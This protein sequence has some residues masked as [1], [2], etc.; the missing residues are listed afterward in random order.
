M[1]SD[2]KGILSVI[3]IFPVNPKT[4]EIRKL[5]RRRSIVREFSLNTSMHGIPGIARSESVQNR[6]FWT[7]IFLI[8]ASIMFFFI[9]QAIRAYFDYPTQTSV[10]IISER[11]QQFPALTFCNAGAFRYDKFIGPFLNYVNNLNL[12]NVM[13][14]DSSGSIQ[15]Q[16]MRSYLPFIINQGQSIEPFMYTLDTMMIDCQFEQTS[17]S[18]KDFISFYSS[19]YGRCFTFNAKTKNS[20]LHYNY[21]SSD[22][23]KLTVRLYLYSYQYV[24]LITEGMGMMAMVHDNEQL[25]LIERAGMTLAPG[26]KHRLTFTKK[27]VYSL[28]SPYSSCTNEIPLAMKI[29][30]DQYEG[31]DYTY[32]EDICY[33][34]CAQAYIYDQCGCVF[35]G[36]WNARSIVLPGTNKVVLAPL[37]NASDS[38]FAIAMHNFDST[39]SIHDDY[40]SYCSQQ[41]SITNF[42]VKSSIMTTPSEWLMTTIKNFVENSSV[43]LASDWSTQ[44]REHIRTSYLSL[45][46]SGEST[47]I[48]NYTETASMGFVDVISNVGGQTGLWIGISFLS[49]MEV[50][51]MLYRLIRYHIYLVRRGL[52]KNTNV[53]NTPKPDYDIDSIRIKDSKN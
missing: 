7:I 25:P 2:Q 8:F 36:Q 5:R 21:M 17:C 50:I 32:S 19:A 11:Q 1:E 28:P 24:S 48:E 6:I 30:F 35:P 15:T 46:L 53:P 12:T 33:I 40:C 39:P 44:W 22:V 4:K 20:S 38:C 45:E 47:L 3:N 18:A 43:P 41:C 52:T 37:C 10:S 26:F 34:I 49:L 27:T 9:I 42:I 16:L 29:M 13:N 14:A 51:E 31:A 23:S